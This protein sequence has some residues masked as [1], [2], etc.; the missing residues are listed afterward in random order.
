MGEA[1]RRGTYDERRVEGIARR[2]AERIERE[3]LRVVREKARLEKIKSMSQAQRRK[4]ANLAAVLGAVEVYNM[5]NP[6][7]RQ[8]EQGGID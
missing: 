4:I 5:T 6:D 1:R 8:K 2:E 3:R 7:T